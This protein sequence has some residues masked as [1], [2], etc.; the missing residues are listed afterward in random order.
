[1]SDLP[2]PTAAPSQPACPIIRRASRRGYT[3]VGHTIEND[4]PSLRCLLRKRQAGREEGPAPSHRLLAFPEL[5]G[6]HQ[7]QS[8]TPARSSGSP[9]PAGE[10]PR[11]LAAKPSGAQRRRAGRGGLQHRPPPLTAVPAAAPALRTRPR[12]PLALFR[13]ACALR[14]LACVGA[15][16]V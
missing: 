4:S 13:S 2:L 11:P 14:L 5:K 8:P 6:R 7:A 3:A 1:M 15:G 12:R 9:S 16:Q 10:T